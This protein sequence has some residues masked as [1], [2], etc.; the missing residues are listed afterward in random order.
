MGLFDLFFKKKTQSIS[1]PSQSNTTQRE[2]GSLIYEKL[3]NYTVIDLETSSKYSNS[4][5]VIELAAARVRK[6]IIV[7]TYTTLIKPNEEISQRITAIT[8]ITNEMLLNAP[9]IQQKLGE[10]LSF[11]GKDIVLGHNICSF[12]STI[13]Y[14][15]CKKY[16]FKPFNNNMLDTLHYAHKCNIK[17]MNYRLPTLARYF[18]VQYNAHRALNDCIA[19]YQVYEKLKPLY[20]GIYQNPVDRKAQSASNLKTCSI[21]KTFSDIS[22]KSIVLTGDF[23]I[24]EKDDIQNKLE[25][26]GAIIRRDVTG[27]TDYVIIGNL[28]HSQ[29]YYGSYGRKIEKAL[30]LQKQGKS[31]MLIEEDEFFIWNK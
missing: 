1:T 23:E 9:T 4:A 2:K 31:I 13:I 28:G 14:D 16:G 22:G 12:D 8:G 10:F 15:L 19:N 6:G 25:T 27:K 29:W 20:T 11:I 18:K 21:N 24:G 30:E 17:V 3:K 5:D 26:L 7:A